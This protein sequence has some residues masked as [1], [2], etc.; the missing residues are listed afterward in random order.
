MRYIVKINNREFQTGD[1]KFKRQVGMESQVLEGYFQIVGSTIP[2]IGDT[3]TVHK[4]ILGQP[5]V[6]K[7]QGKIS[8]VGYMPTQ[9]AQMFI[10]AYDMLRKISYQ[11]SSVK[12]FSTPTKCSGNFSSQIAPQTKTDLTA[13]SID[14]TDSPPDSVN[15]GKTITGGD[16]LLHRNQCL[17]I[18]QM[19]SNRDIYVSKAGAASF[20]NG[21]G[22]D[23]STGSNKMELVDGINGSIIGEIGYFEDDTRIVKKVIV[24]GKGAGVK[25]SFLGQAVDGSYTTNDKMRQF[26]FPWLVSNQTCNTVAANILAELNKRVKYTKFQMTPDPFYID[27]DIFDTVKLKARLPN[28]TVNENLK[29]YSIETEVSLGKELSEIVTLELVNFNRGIWAPLLMPNKAG[30]ASENNIALSS[31]STQAQDHVG[32]SGGSSVITS[33]GF[34]SATEVVDTTDT[35][36]LTVAIAASPRSAGI[37][38]MIPYRLIPR[39]RTTNS[40]NANLT[41]YAVAYTSAIDYSAF[42][43]MPYPSY[44]GKDHIGY[45]ELYIPADVAGCNIDI[46]GAVDTGEIDLQIN[47][48]FIV[49][50]EHSH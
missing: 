20:V 18:L 38:I 34:T 39:K 15:F 17:D 9:K 32:S 11:E 4:E 14:T 43:T 40:E 8:G 36:L 22:T 41:M 37:H 6:L 7:F 28:K 10:S 13:G 42:V 16:S 46:R 44:R 50:G 24:K 23:R 35:L 3:I 47:P 29:I 48:S 26:E 2:Q 5:K 19:I 25:D 33:Q 45:L 49:I 31:I 1:F 30:S 12:G 27:Y 21:A